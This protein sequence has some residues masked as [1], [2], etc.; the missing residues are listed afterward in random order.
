[1]AYKKKSQIIDSICLKSLRDSL[2]LS[3]LWLVFPPLKCNDFPKGNIL[4]MFGDPEGDES[5]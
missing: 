5:S 3:V 1:M 2:C 4:G